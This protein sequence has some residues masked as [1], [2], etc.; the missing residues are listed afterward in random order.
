MVTP[1]TVKTKPGADAIYFQKAEK[2]LGGSKLLLEKENWNSAA[3]L[4]IHATISACDAIC[5]KLLG[6]R[7]SGG[8]H[9]V[10]AYLLR[11]LP[12]DRNEVET[13]IKQANRV[14]QIKNMAE[15]E[16]KLVRESDAREAVLSAERIISW[17]K[18]KL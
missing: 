18:E 8:E 10:A 12:F 4:A 2:F 6:R 1:Q 13:K 11:E 14:I 16:D 9:A 5:A 7:H 3:V 17:V 15:Y